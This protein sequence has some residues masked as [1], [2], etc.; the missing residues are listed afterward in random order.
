MKRFGILL[1]CLA[2]VS[3]ALADVAAA[4]DAGRKARVPFSMLTVSPE[5]VEDA[6]KELFEKGLVPYMMSAAEELYVAELF[7]SSEASLDNGR[8]GPAVDDPEAEYGQDSG[9]TGTRFVYTRLAYGADAIQMSQ[10]IPWVRPRAIAASAEILKTCSY[11]LSTVRIE[12]A[13][14]VGW[15]G[16]VASVSNR[17]LL[18]TIEVKSKT[19]TRQETRYCR[20]AYHAED[21]GIIFDGILI[22]DY[23]R[24]GYPKKLQD[25]QTIK[26]LNRPLESFVE[27]RQPFTEKADRVYVSKLMERITRIA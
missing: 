19:S 27:L 12:K 26:S 23:S 1:V 11:R 17:T 14:I 2:L 6:A 16:S 8:P 3:A 21:D 20:I 15:D 9:G 4:D 25:T 10:E 22:G 13:K 7:T 18:D 24:V 5:K